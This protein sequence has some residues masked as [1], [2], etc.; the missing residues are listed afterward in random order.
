M[1]L[2]SIF[3]PSDKMQDSLYAPTCTKNWAHMKINI[4][5]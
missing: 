4:I 1:N 3:S 2:T 5:L